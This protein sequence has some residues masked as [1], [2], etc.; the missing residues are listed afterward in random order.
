MQNKPDFYGAIPDKSYK[1][2]KLEII[3]SK[4]GQSRIFE[5]ADVAGCAEK[6]F[7]G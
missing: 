7:R 4:S 2:Q 6:I 1:T 5:I 3:K